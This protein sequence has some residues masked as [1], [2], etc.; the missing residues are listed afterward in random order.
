ME[1]YGADYEEAQLGC[2]PGVVARCFFLRPKRYGPDSPLYSIRYRTVAPG[3]S[4]WRSNLPQMLVHRGKPFLHSRAG[5]WADRRHGLRQACCRHL[6]D[7][8]MPCW[9]HP[10]ASA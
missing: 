5:A 7:T 4:A 2:R 1:E 9:F 3:S 6:M 8:M 10:T